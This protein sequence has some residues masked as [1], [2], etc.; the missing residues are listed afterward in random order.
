M[1]EDIEYLEWL[2]AGLDSIQDEKEIK[3]LR[4][5]IKSLEE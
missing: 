5:R 2:I 1:K 3:Q 4:K